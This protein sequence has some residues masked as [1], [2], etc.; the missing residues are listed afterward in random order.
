LYEHNQWLND[1]ADG[2]TAAGRILVGELHLGDTD[3]NSLM[4]AEAQFVFR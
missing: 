3:C 2:S 4:L 1:A